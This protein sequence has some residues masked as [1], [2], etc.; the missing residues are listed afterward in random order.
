MQFSFDSWLNQ[1][2]ICSFC[3]IN[4][5]KNY[6]FC[7]VRFCIS[8]HLVANSETPSL[9][10]GTNLPRLLL[11]NASHPDARSPHLPC[12]D[13]SKTLMPRSVTCLAES[14]T[15]PW[16][17]LS[18]TGV[19]PPHTLPDL[20]PSNTCFRS[21]YWV[22]GPILI[23]PAMG[24][25]QQLHSLL[26]YPGENVGPGPA[27]ETTATDV[28]IPKGLGRSQDRPPGWRKLPCLHWS[29]WCSIN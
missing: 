3:K 1:R 10:T 14:E 19:P 27:C 2:R 7:V 23:S 26:I 13:R 4:K 17:H 12:A 28:R 16:H 5:N 9:A 21:G 6:L 8:P 22:K 18:P 11:N 20:K 29:Q 25:Y 15:K 24:L